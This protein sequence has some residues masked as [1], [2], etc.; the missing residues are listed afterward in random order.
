MAYPSIMRPV[1]ATSVFVGVAAVG[2]W[3]LIVHRQ[4]TIAETK[5][6]TVSTDIS[7]AFKDSTTIKSLVNPRGHQSMRDSHHMR[8]KLPPHLR[9]VSDEAILARFTKGFFGGWT[10]TPERTALRLMG[11]RF[12]SYAS[13]DILITAHT[14][15]LLTK[16]QNSTS[17]ALNITYGL[18]QEYQ[19]INYLFFIQSC[20]EDSK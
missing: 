1:I 15:K 12:V 17:L 10:L 8:L 16:E 13:K 5:H 2:T 4:I 7:S 18:H 20:L 6:I 3:A 19:M 14:R 11:K 9:D